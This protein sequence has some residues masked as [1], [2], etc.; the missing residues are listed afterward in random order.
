[1][2]IQKFQKIPDD[3]LEGIQY[4]GSNYA[5]ITAWCPKTTYADGKLTI[6]GG[7]EIPATCWV[8][9]DVGSNYLLWPNEQLVAYYTPIDE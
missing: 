5:E 9:Q 3:K 1:M 2:A 6:Y 4:T 7:M 8:M